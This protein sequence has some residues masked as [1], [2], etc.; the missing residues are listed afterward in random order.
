[1]RH[2]HNELVIDRAYWCPYAQRYD[3][4]NPEDFLFVVCQPWPGVYRDGHLWHTGLPSD[5]PMPVFGGMFF[6]D[7]REEADSFAADNVGEEYILDGET[8]RRTHFSADSSR[9]GPAATDVKISELKATALRLGAEL[10]VVMRMPDG[11]IANVEI[12]D[13]PVSRTDTITLCTEDGDKR[14]VETIDLS[15]NLQETAHD[16][17]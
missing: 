6:F 13:I 11:S 9:R 15:A 1:M 16:G 3:L 8:L 12:G 10:I 5:L 7:T 2:A 14:S 4:Q 17:T